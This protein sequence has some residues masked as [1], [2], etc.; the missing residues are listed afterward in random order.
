MGGTIVE[1]ER[2]LD[3]YEIDR[4]SRPI[5]EFI[6]DLSVWYLRRS[7]DRFKSD[8]K[9]D[10]EEAI[11]TTYHVLKET[12]KLLAPICPF[13]AEEIYLKLKKASESESV[14][15][16]KWPNEENNLVYIETPI[17]EEMAA[18]RQIVSLAL[19]FRQAA[20]LKVRQPLRELRVKSQYLALRPEYHNLILEELN[21]KKLVFDPKLSDEVWLDTEMDDGL[22]QEGE[23]REFIRN[24]QEYRK[25]LGLTPSDKI[26]LCVEAPD[27]GREMLRRFEKEVIKAAGLKRLDYGIVKEGWEILVNGKTFKVKIGEND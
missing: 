21:V 6:E 8:D 2:V 16:A 17:G 20:G 10:R 27:E 12:A 4:A 5:E 11:A 9:G 14:H 19:E 26:V 13:V 3:N 15:L 23:S 25:S 7:R 22:K 18:V 1:V 24:L